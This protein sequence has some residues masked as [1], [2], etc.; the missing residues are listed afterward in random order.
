M[1]VREYICACLLSHR[2]Y[3]NIKKFCRCVPVK[4]AIKAGL[5]ARAGP[6]PEWLPST[7]VPSPAHLA[8]L[9]HGLLLRLCGAAACPGGA[10]H[11]L[12]L[13]CRVIAHWIGRPADTEA[14]GTLL[15]TVAPLSTQECARLA[16]LF[17]RGAAPGSEPDPSPRSGA[18]PA[19]MPAGAAGASAASTRGP[20]V[21]EAAGRACESHARLGSEWPLVAAFVAAQPALA[22]AH[23]VL[24]SAF[25]CERFLAAAVH[26]GVSHAWCC[27]GPSRARACM[28]VIPST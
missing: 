7:A 22:G 23:G 12:N 8:W 19:A 20:D 11:A 9:A 15:R 2:L 21:G 27:Q 14:A 17:L 5:L 28:Q 4:T 13:E 26:N 3:Y 6:P 18:A 25:L 1:P 10:L 16:A 24:G